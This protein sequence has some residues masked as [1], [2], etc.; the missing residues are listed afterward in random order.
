MDS[1]IN[2][3]SRICVRKWNSEIKKSM[4]NLKIPQKEEWHNAKPCVIWKK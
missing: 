4:K 3:S 1:I 2:P